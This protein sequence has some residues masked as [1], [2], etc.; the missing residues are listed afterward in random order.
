MRHT[1]KQ[2]QVTLYDYCQDL[3]L[4]IPVKKNIKQYAI[5]QPNFFKIHNDIGNHTEKEKNNNIFKEHHK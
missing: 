1:K 2:R 5:F 3:Y 4:Q